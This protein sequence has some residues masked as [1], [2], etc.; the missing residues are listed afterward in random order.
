MV[1]LVVR[2]VWT[3]EVKPV[4]WLISLALAVTSV[5]PNFRPAVAPS[6]EA[7]LR[8]CVSVGTPIVTT[9]WALCVTTLLSADWPNVTPVIEDKVAPVT[10]VPPT[11]KLPEAVTF[12]PEIA[13]AVTSP[14]FILPE[15]DTLLSEK[16]ITL[17]VAVISS[18]LN[19]NPPTKPEDPTLSSPVVL[20]FS[21]PK[22]SAPD[23]EVIEPLANVISPIIDPE[24]AWTVPVIT[25]LPLTDR[26]VAVIPPDVKLPV[27][28]RSSLPKSIWPEAD[29]SSPVPIVKSPIT[30]PVAAA[31]VPVVVKSLEPNEIPSWPEDTIEPSEIVTSPNEPLVVADTVVPAVIPAVA[32]TDP[33]LTDPLVPMVLAPKLTAPVLELIVPSPNVI[34][35]NLDWLA[36]VTVPVADILPVIV[37]SPEANVPVVEILLAPKVNPA[38]SD[39]IEPLANVISANFEFTGA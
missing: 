4:R 28:I 30:E 10:S 39:V 12:V 18:L 6:W 2:P 8:I 13:D 26:D 27:V 31:T 5:P 7:I 25:E 16:L 37:V 14:T 19:V 33:T 38:L 29:V 32:S 1:Y 17:L 23:E 9:P 11:V 3:D 20:R 15:V 24:A 36:P 34:L 35:P 22:L 21:S